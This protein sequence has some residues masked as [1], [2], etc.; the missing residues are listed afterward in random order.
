MENKMEIEN[1][2]K[3]ELEVLLDKLF[4]SSS[5]KHYQ[6]FDFNNYLGYQNL[7]N[8]LSDT[9]IL[10]NV[11][12][13]MLSRYLDIFIGDKYN[14]I[15]NKFKNKYNIRVKFIYNKY[16]IT[17]MI[18]EVIFNRE[19]TEELDNLFEQ[20]KIYGNYVFNNQVKYNE[21]VKMGYEAVVKSIE[22]NKIEL[23]DMKKK[24]N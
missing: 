7:D 24:T 2:I 14:K 11:F 15:I 18:L 20:L 23:G 5:L 21:I 4:N 17:R 10:P 6:D 8:I 1:E 12:I 13:K 16:Q 3:N 9:K 19:N 22:F